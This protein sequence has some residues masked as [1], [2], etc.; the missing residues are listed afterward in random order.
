MLGNIVKVELKYK[1][2]SGWFVY[3]YKRE[4]GELSK[5]NYLQSDNKELL[6]E[7]ISKL[8]PDFLVVENFTLIRDSKLWY[9]PNSYH[10]HNPNSYQ[11][12]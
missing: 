4:N 6:N 5:N 12:Q 1:V 2:D 10:D 7:I 11:I 3:F 9:K 8:F